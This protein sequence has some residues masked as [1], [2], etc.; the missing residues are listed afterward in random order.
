MNEE[1]K[2]RD[3]LNDDMDLVNLLRR[4]S[5]ESPRDASPPVEQTITAAFRVLHP[6]KKPRTWLYAAAAAAILLLSLTLLRQHASTS[7]NV[8]S[9]PGFVALPY[10][11]SG[12]PLEYVVV[13]RVELRPSELNALGIPSPVASSPAKLTA[14][15]MLGQDGIPRAFRF[16]Q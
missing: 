12:V 8:Y 4:L 9:A 13:V 6:R 7:G 1:R 16:I 15:L 5:S 14:D 10:S 11:Q 3:R 2:N